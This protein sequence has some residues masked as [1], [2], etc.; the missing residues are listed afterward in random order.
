ME[1]IERQLADREVTAVGNETNQSVNEN[2]DLPDEDGVDVPID[3]EALISRCM[4]NLEFAD[5]LL[6]DFQ[7]DLPQQVDQIA[8]F[9]DQGD[10]EAM[11]DT[12]HSLKGAA[13]IVV[14]ETI[15]TIVTEIE[16][17]GKAADLTDTPSLTEQLQSE[18][19]RCL[20]FIPRLRE[21]IAVKSPS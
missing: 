19:Q 14:A 18:T 11:T 6:A 13:G 5:S 12:A 7:E 2:S 21:E 16:M 20:G 10:I 3:R 8:T 15:R 4:G 1:K 9:A 17:A